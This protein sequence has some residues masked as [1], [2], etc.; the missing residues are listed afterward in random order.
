MML[1]PDILL[2]FVLSVEILYPNRRTNADGA[3]I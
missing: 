2:K 3:C 1:P